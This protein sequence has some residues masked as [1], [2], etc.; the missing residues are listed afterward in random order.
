[1]KQ[2]K[3]ALLFLSL[4]AGMAC[5][6]TYD[7]YYYDDAYYDSYYGAYDAAWSYAWVDP[8]YSYWYYAIGKV[9][10]MAVDPATAATQLAANA[11]TAFTPSGCAT[12]TA[13]GATVNYTFN[14][15]QAAISLTQISGSVE[16]VLADNQ[17]QLAATANST[18]LT[19]NG[20]PYNLSLQIAGSPPQGDQRKVTVTSNSFSPNRFDSRTS[21]STVTWVAG[22]GCI[23][24]D[25]T[26]QATK[27]GLSSTTTVS[28]YQRCDHQCPTAG[29]VQ[30]ET[31]EGTFTATYDGSNTVKVVA[32]NDDVK[33][34]NLDC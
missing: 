12:A 5:T 19:I 33:T 31:A 2:M 14:N 13:T 15:C 4:G 30:V 21:T 23:T 24:V 29:M 27:G 32:P 26:S 25:S 7:P 10:A 22:S 8:V 17:G 18:N 3:A 28:G 1:M 20:E 11:S 9:Q 34:Y 16:V 6:S